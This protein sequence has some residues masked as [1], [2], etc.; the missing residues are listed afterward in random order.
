M[1]KQQGAALIVVLSLLTVSLMLGLSGVQSSL[2]DERLAGNY[3][4]ST[5]A[6]MAAE[7]SVSIGYSTLPN[8]ITDLTIFS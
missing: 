2:I 3:K 5:Q 7:Q 1:K 8:K 4:N 6:Q